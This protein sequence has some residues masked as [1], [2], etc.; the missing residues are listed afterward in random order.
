MFLGFLLGV[1]RPFT[2]LVTAWL[3]AMQSSS[4]SESK[5]SVVHTTWLFNRDML[6]IGMVIPSSTLD[7]FR[8]RGSNGLIVS[9]RQWQPEGSEISRECNALAVLL[10]NR[11]VWVLF[12]CTH[13]AWRFSSFAS[14]LRQGESGLKS[15]QN[16]LRHHLDS[17]TRSWRTKDWFTVPK[18]VQKSLRLM[19]FCFVT[20]H[21]EYIATT[22][23]KDMEVRGSL[24]RSPAPTPHRFP[25]EAVP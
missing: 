4:I 23:D 16:V 10:K 25:H 22:T 21:L 24:W 14:T 5:E 19:N 1:F 8:L 18:Y 9:M 6:Q 3:T 12:T 20:E 13:C 17:C 7:L 2:V 11:I 15:H